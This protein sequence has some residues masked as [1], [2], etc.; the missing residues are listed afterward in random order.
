M[1]SNKLGIL[2]VKIMDFFNT[3]LAVFYNT[4]PRREN[5]TSPSPCPKKS[6]FDWSN[7]KTVFHLLHCK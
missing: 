3:Y 4:V 5:E 1:L 2:K 7:L 6:N